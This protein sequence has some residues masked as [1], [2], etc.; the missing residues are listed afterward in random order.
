M[1]SKENLERLYSF[2]DC[3]SKV[4][5]IT[6]EDCK[7]IME[8]FLEKKGIMLDKTIEKYCKKQSE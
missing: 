4:G 1:A 8:N 2:I 7:Q 3:C 5:L 6:D